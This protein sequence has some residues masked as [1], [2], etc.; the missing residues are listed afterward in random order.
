MYVCVCIII[1]G[2]FLLLVFG[3]KVGNQENEREGQK[4][5]DTRGR[6]ME[7]KETRKQK[8]GALLSLKRTIMPSETLSTF[9][10]F[11]FFSCFFVNLSC[12]LIWNGVE[13]GEKGKNNNSRG[14]SLMQ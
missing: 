3:R 11:F 1:L 9:G 5:W 13:Q 14:S 12:K 4:A 2:L 8:N 6:E 7:R 10:Y